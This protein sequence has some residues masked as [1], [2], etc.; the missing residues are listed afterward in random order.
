MNSDLPKYMIN[1]VIKFYVFVHQIMQ[2]LLN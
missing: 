2:I 1:T